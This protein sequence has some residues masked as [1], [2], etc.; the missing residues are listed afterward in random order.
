MV[1]FVELEGPEAER[2][3]STLEG[4]LRQRSE[5]ETTR[6]LKSLTQPVYLL[7]CECSS[8]PSVN[9]PEDAWVWRFLEL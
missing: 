7:L 6:L 5:V 8:P 4:D 2:R 9:W 1:L 3:L